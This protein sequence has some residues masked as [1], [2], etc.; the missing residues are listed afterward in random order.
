MSDP[1]EGELEAA[2]LLLRRMGVTPEQLLASAGSGAKARSIPTFNEYVPQVALAVSAASHRLYGTYWA[3][4]CDAW[5][6]RR[7]DEP[8]P[9][10][11]K[12]LAELVKQQAVVRRN[13]RGG[14]GAAEHLISALRCLYKQ[15]IDD[16]LIGEHDNPALRVDKPGRAT[17][18]RRGLRDA[19]LAEII[20]VA[21]ST[22]NDPHLDALMLRLHIET[23]CRRGGA[24]GLRLRDL[25]EKRSVIYLREKGET[26][27]WQPV[28]PSLLRGL[29]EH[30]AERGGVLET[31]QIL[32]SKR[33]TPITRRRYDYLWTRVG[34]HL[35]W[36][37][38]QGISTHWL[39]HTT[40][41]FVER[42]SGYAVAQAYAGHTTGRGV[43]T[44]ATYVSADIHEVARALEM[45]TNEKHPLAIF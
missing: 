12:Q 40:L 22:G 10:E 14:R 26:V 37:A 18:T 21:S 5:G 28:S 20:Q 25:E 11:I 33:F 35:P 15:A 36:V 45:L 30:F 9:L 3:K 27:R 32:R 43:G 23:A 38:T 6:E 8:T 24:L 31:D 16:R 44:T 13:T 17:S 19:E 2:L 42:N 7:I 39:R 41:T 1:S 34:E 29:R 4:V